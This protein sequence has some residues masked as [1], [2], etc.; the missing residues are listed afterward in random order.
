MST[1]D[2]DRARLK[3]LVA[4]I[5]ER[6]ETAQGIKRWKG[7]SD[8]LDEL[9]LTLLSQ[10]TNDNNR[11]MAYQRLREKY[12]TW[13]QVREAGAGAVAERIK[14]AGLANQKSGRM[15]DILRWIDDTYGDLNLDFLHDMPVE[16]AFETFTQ[17]KGVGVKTMAVVLMFACGRD[18]FPVD[19]HVH[20]ICRRL[21]LVP[22]NADAVKT[23]HLMAPLVPE[24]KGYSLHMNFLQFGRTICAA[25]SPRC[26]AC[27]LNDL[28]P[29]EGK[30]DL[31]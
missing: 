13:R 8:P 15:I 28:C 12:P 29:W 1:K 3:A 26:G 7:K 22:D 18:I 6:L 27:P 23:F 10:S 24:G 21:A 17:L 2:T 14:P 30:T 19:T 11:D 20:R 5:T 16:E 25:R 4:E 9:M 31:T